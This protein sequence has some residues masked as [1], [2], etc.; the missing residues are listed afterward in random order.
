MSSIS[1]F[2]ATKIGYNPIKL[3]LRLYA[4]F[5][6][7]K[8]Q[9]NMLVELNH[10]IKP[11]LKHFR[12]LSRTA[13]INLSILGSVFLFVLYVL[14][15]SFLLKLLLA[16]GL[17]LLITVPLLSQFFLFGLPILAW[18]FL[19]FSAGKIPTSWKPPISVKILPSMETILYGDDLSDVLASYTS[20]P[21][22]FVAWFPY[23]IVHFAGP[24]IVAALVWLFGPPTA[25]RSFGWS[26]GYMN[27]VGVAIQQIFPAAP[28]WYKNLY[29]LQPAN[30]AMKGSPGGLG[31]MDGYFGVDLYTT[32][33]SNAPVIFGA[34]P[35]LHSGISTM[36]AL[37]LSYLFPKYS[38]Y[39]ACYVCWLWWSTMYLTHHY[40]FDLTAGSVL[41]V[42]FFFVAKYQWL[43]LKKADCFCRF[44]YYRL[45]YEDTLQNDPL[46]Y[47]LRLSM[48]DA[49]ELD[50]ATSSGESTPVD[51]DATV[52]SSLF[53]A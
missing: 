40:F 5:L 25:L 1:S 49:V 6:A 13:V 53:T 11:T 27:L 8:K 9:N 44:N 24:F 17:G 52:E 2:P 22:D 16:L 47:E 15:I 12:N 4:E 18:V 14:P 32:N 50:D 34:F 26:F 42:T 30:Y 10:D 28:P 19:F 29:G 51:D 36:N 3:I 23:G 7:A 37:W 41:A 45:E 33:F 31:R 21:L 43:P 38:P 39:F 48:D 35:S 46:N 20:K